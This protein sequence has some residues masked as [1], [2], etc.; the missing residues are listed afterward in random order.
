MGFFRVRVRYSRGFVTAKGRARTAPKSNVTCDAWNNGRQCAPPAVAPPAGLEPVPPAPEAGLFVQLVLPVRSVPIV[1]SRRSSPARRSMSGQQPP[2]D[3]HFGL[4]RPR[5]RIDHP[6]TLAG[7]CVPSYGVGASEIGPEA[8]EVRP[9]ISF[10]AWVPGPC[11]P[12]PSQRVTKLGLLVD[13]EARAIDPPLE[14]FEQAA[15]DV[16]N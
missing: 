6:L 7:S 9:R 1:L 15:H 13:V 5:S 3:C 12:K 14:L 16:D 8:V 10:S 11:A 4:P 2:F